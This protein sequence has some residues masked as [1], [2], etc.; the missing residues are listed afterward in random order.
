MWLTLPALRLHVPTLRLHVAHKSI[1]LL[2]LE[3]ESDIVLSSHILLLPVV[4]HWIPWTLQQ[5]QHDSNNIP[6]SRPHQ[7]FIALLSGWNTADGSHNSPWNDAFCLIGMLCKQG[8]DTSLKGM[9]LKEMVPYNLL[10]LMIFW[11]PPYLQINL[12]FTS[13]HCRLREQHGLLHC[14]FCCHG[15]SY[16]RSNKVH[17]LVKS[18]SQAVGEMAWQLLRV[19]T[20]YRCNVIAITLT[21]SSYWICT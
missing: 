18:H 9:G 6:V 19:Q 11:I 17:L 14:H 12:K 10:K 5:W 8:R 3:L 4:L 15:T 16:R 21:H 7:D 13:E 2:L 1:V 20:V